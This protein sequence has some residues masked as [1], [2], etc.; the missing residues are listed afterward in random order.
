M[1]RDTVLWLVISLG[2]ALMLVLVLVAT[3]PGGNASPPGVSNVPDPAGEETGPAVESPAEE[4]SVTAGERR[5]GQE[6]EGTRVAVFSPGDKVVLIASTGT[7]GGTVNKEAFDAF[8]KA[9]LA[10]DEYGLVELAASSQL[11]AIES[12][13]QALVLEQDRQRG[14]TEVRIK[15]GPL[16]GL[17]LWVDTANVRSP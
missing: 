8:V 11:I 2:L 3:Y 10:D 17:A 12:G 7:L 9:I 14:A 6:F 4:S 1:K 15:S 13:T 5:V 16:T